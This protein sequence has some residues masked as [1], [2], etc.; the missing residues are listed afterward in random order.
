MG[1]S[2]L[3]R[4]QEEYK[5]LSEEPGQ[6]SLGACQWFYKVRHFPAK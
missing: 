6:P 4:Q 5:L 3:C 2:G 1:D